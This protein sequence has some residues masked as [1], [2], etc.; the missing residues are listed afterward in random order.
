MIKTSSLLAKLAKRF[1]KRYAKEYHDRI[2]LMAGKLPEMV[3]TIF[4]ALDFDSLLYDEVAA[5]KPDLILTH[6]PFVYHPRS[7]IKKDDPAKF[8]LIERVEHA[9]LCVYSL[10]TNFDRGQGGMNDALTEALGLRDI[11]PLSE[12]PMARGGYLGT[13]L[14]IE[15][16]A[17]YAKER[18][19]ATYGLLLPYGKKIIHRV[20]IIGG[21]GSRSYSI[22]QKEGY[23][24]FISGD[25][26]HHVRRG[27][28]NDH[29][30]YLDLPHEIESIFIP[31]MEKILHSID[32]S[33]IIKKAP[34]QAQAQLI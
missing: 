18:L 29:Y 9:G 12:E 7:V 17:S 10:H 6:H 30:N 28:I 33:L 4:L 11:Q 31:Q 1:P 21:G 16:F 8:A 23:D 5:L 15:V 34:L 20:A 2:G 22:A 27:I 3:Q 25:M 19:H 14:P 32:S 26:P 24:L 13:P